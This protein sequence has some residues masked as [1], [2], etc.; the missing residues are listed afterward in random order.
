MTVGVLR[1]QSATPELLERFY[2]FVPRPTMRAVIVLEDDEPRFVA[3]VY[4]LECIDMAFTDARPGLDLSRM[5]VLRA[6]KHAM[7]FVEESAARARPV[8]ALCDGDS[9]LLERLGF[10]CHHGDLYQWPNY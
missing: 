7:R 9:A 6:I 10:T 1:A 8:Y 4:R 5:T 2:G 3:G